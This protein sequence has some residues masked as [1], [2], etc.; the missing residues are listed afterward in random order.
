MEQPHERIA[1]GQGPGLIWGI[2]F[3]P[4]ERREVENCNSPHTGHVRWLHLNLADHGTRLWIETTSELSAPAREILLSQDKHQRA[5]VD[6]E[7]V[8]CVLH[9]FERDFDVRD[10]GRIGALRMVL[11]PGL[12]VSARHHPIGSA[13]IA[14]RRLR[15]S[16]VIASPARGLDLIVGAI[17]ENFGRVIGS[18]SAEVQVA[19]DAL[20]EERQVPNSHRLMDIRRRLAQLHRMLEGMQG[21]FR[22]LEIDQD[23]PGEILPTVEKLSQRVQGVD[24]D[25]QSVMSQLRAVRDEINDQSNL[26]MNQNLYILSVMTALLLPTTLV[27]GIFGM[28]TGDL[29]LTGHLGTIGATVIAAASALATYLFLRTRGFFR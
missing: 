7:T 28:N 20:V 8:A 16:E 3:V 22:R 13:D 4:G 10:T 14:R 12:I 15:D 24:G 29:P 2:D 26:R 18:L 1:L 17:L 25:I 9:D 27:T 11:T 6:A 21:V 5:L 19:E 23:L